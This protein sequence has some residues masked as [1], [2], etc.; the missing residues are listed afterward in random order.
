VTAADGTQIR[1][2]YD[3]VGRERSWTDEA[4]RVTQLLYDLSDRLVGTILSDGTVV[5][6]SLGLV[7]MGLE[8]ADG[9]LEQATRNAM[10]QNHNNVP[11]GHYHRGCT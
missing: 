7:G 6:G 1:T 11:T 9:W 10:Y 5:T 2:T 8:T 4:G 3:L